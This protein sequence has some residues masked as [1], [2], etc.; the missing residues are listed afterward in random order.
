[1]RTASS[2]SAHRRATAGSPP[3]SDPDGAAPGVQVLLSAFAQTRS[4]MKEAEVPLR[5]WVGGSLRRPRASGH[6]DTATG[7]ARGPSD[8]AFRRFAD[9]FLLDPPAFTPRPLAAR[10]QAV[11]VREAENAGRATFAEGLASSYEAF[12]ETRSNRPAERDEEEQRARNLGQHRVQRAREPLRSEI[13]NRAS[14]SDGLC[15][16]P[17]DCSARCNGSR[18]LK[19]EARR[20]WCSVITAKRDERWCDILLLCWRNGFGTTPRRGLASLIE[21]L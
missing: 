17:E 13:G 16:A 20:W 19:V 12:L 2:R 6:S 7:T 10:A 14:R 8:S 9:A 15:P 5:K 11:V 1:M 18:M 3:N 21:C 4:A